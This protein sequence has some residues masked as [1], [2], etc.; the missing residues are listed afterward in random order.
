MV[1]QG[2]AILALAI[3][4]LIIII[5]AETITFGIFSV[6]VGVVFEGKQ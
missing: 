5:T 6:I 3:I 4:I 2:S 1:Q